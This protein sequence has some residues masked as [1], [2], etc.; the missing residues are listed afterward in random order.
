MDAHYTEWH[1]EHLV[2]RTLRGEP[3]S[4][5]AVVFADEWIGRLRLSAQLFLHD[6]DPERSFSYRLGFPSSLVRGGGSFRFAPTSDGGCEMREEVQLGFSIPLV[7]PLVDLLLAIALPL[8]ELRR[9]MREE[10]ERLVRLLRTT[11]SEG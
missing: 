4:E 7:G 5:G 8:G 2:W 11:A 3:L 9:H 10:G 6:V 1:P